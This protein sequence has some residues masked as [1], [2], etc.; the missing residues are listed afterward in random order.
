MP[1]HPFLWVHTRFEVPFW[2][3]IGNEISPLHRKVYF[4]L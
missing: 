4:Q 2:M 1:P 3:M